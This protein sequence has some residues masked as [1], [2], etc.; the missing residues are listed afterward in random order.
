MS[1][2]LFVVA[3]PIGNLE[4]ITLRALAVLR[5]ADAIACEDTRVTAKLLA[6]HQIQKPLFSIHEHSEARSLERAIERLLAGESIAYV[7]D[8]GTPGVNDPGGKLV[9]AC[10]EAGVP[11]VPIPGAS[12]LA[13]AISVCGFPMDDFV[14]AGFVPHKK[15][16]VTLFTEIA[17]RKTPT[18]FF[19][20]T[21]RIQKTL[22]ALSEYLPADRF[23]FIGRE[24]T[25]LHETLYRG[26]IDEVREALQATSLKGEFVVIIAPES[27][28]AKR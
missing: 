10:F 23:V 2:S 27:L 5:D 8:A 7:S 13:A 26:S 3:T 4:D 16:R 12:A 20:S 17:A 19:E 15:G 11:V 21:H 1:G 22:D 28:S 9:A 18:V 14:Y 24:L 6:R 25:K